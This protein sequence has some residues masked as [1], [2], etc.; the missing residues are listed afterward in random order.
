MYVLECVSFN[1]LYIIGIHMIID[2]LTIEA[3][4]WI[5]CIS[6]YVNQIYQW[7]FLI[8]R[9]NSSIKLDGRENGLFLNAIVHM[10]Y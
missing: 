5:R 7:M 1:N 8:V 10:L 3:K 4:V 9:E 6:H 2:L